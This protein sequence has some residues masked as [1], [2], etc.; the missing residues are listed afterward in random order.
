MGRD[1]KEKKYLGKRGRGLVWLTCV[2]W[3]TL[4]VGA[5]YVKASKPC[6]QRALHTVPHFNCCS[7][8]VLAL[9]VMVLYGVD[10]GSSGISLR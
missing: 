2:V 9:V 5:F 6:A 4:K 8:L 1:Q 10:N 7:Y 3:L